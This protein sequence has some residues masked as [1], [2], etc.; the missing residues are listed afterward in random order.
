MQIKQLHLLT[1]PP[2][3]STVALILMTSTYL[4][5]H[6]VFP[7]LGGIKEFIQCM[8]LAQ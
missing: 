3:I 7:D 8:V 6:I 5:M 2:P 1:L 4:Q